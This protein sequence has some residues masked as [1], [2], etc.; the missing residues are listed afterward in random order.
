[1]QHYEPVMGIPHNR[2]VAKRR[3]KKGRG[4]LNTRSARSSRKQ[5][6]ARAGNNHRRST[7]GKQG[8]A[9]KQTF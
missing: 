8:V 2:I 3:Q 5:T 9:G 1:M 6:L 4:R 7:S